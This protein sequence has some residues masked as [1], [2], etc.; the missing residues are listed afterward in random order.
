MIFCCKSNSIRVLKYNIFVVFSA[1][2]VHLSR[3]FA[4]FA[5]MKR[6]FSLF[7]LLLMVVMT[8]ARHYDMTGLRLST[9]DGL[10]TNAVVRIGQNRQ[11]YIVLQ[12]RNGTCL[13]DGY[14]LRR[15]ENS[16][17]AVTDTDKELRT[18]DAV[19]T[20]CGNGLLERRGREGRTDR[21]QLIPPEIISYTRNDHFHVAD[22]DEHTEAIA[23]YGSGLFL[24]DKPTGELTQLTQENSQGLLADDYLTGLFV[25]RT[26][27]IWIIEDYLGVKMLRPN[28]LNYELLLP[29]AQAHIEDENNIRCIAPLEDDHLLVS[30]QTSDVYDYDVQTGS[31]S[32]LYRSNHRVY[33]ALRDHQGRLW[34]GTRGGGLLCDGKQVDSLPSPHIFNLR[35][36]DKGGI[37]VAMLEGGVT[38]INGDKQKHLLKG[39]NVH[40]AIMWQGYLWAA[41]EEGLFHVDN[42]WAVSDS[43][44]GC[45]IC[46]YAD[47]KGSLW[48]GSNDRGV[49]RI[50][51]TEDRHISASFFHTGNGLPSNGV[52]AIS[53]DHSH[54]LWIST[55][56]GLACINP[57]TGDIS[58]YNIFGSPLLN[59]FNERAAVCLPDGRLL[60]GSRGGIVVVSGQK[61]RPE[62]QGKTAVTA[63]TVNGQLASADR[64]LSH[65]ENNLT[66]SFSNFQ[67]ADLQ[68]VHYQYWLEGYDTE[69]CEPTKDHT[70][71]YRHLPPGH[72]VF[73]VRSWSGTGQWSEAANI[74]ITISKPWWDTWWAWLLYIIMIIS[75]TR[76]A[77]GIARRQLRLRRQIDVQRQVNALQ[78]DF[79]GRIEREMRSP[80]NVVQGATEQVRLGETT[81]TTK[82]SLRRGALRL[83]K[84][85]E[86][87]GRYH[88]L[89][90]QELQQKAEHDAMNQETEKLFADIQ[91]TNRRDEPEFREMVPPPINAQT[92]IIAS[93]DADS[94]AHLKDIV[95]P[96]FRVQEVLV[97]EEVTTAVNEYAPD[98][99]MI[100]MNN[101][102]QECLDLT[103]Q[104]VPV[105]LSLPIVHLS[106]YD[107]DE[108]QLRS[109]RS[110]ASDYIVKPVGNR[111]LLE[112][113]KKL[114]AA[115]P[116]PPE[117]A[118]NSA[119][120][121]APPEQ[122]LTSTKDK[123]F[124]N[125]MQ[126]T[127]SAH[128]A[129]E[130]FSVEQ[131]AEAMDLGRTQ[132]Y[133]K[134]KTLTGETPM[135]HLQRER[136]EQAARLLRETRLTVENIMLR[137]GY[138]NASH[139][140][141]TF[142]R[143]FGV[144][145]KVMRNNEQ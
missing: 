45:F 2:F 25:D 10:P 42:S 49:A 62:A 114:L 28:R 134:V 105:H 57:V 92:V 5:P 115:S 44:S 123:R 140:Y 61:Q 117:P 64:R 12:T 128:I 101:H 63:L 103:R 95:S 46:L 38:I 82:Q 78:R 112:R 118:A 132:F 119:A 73:H 11:G 87:I 136:M 39:K 137:V 51:M 109:L 79:L 144:S 43:L 20:R 94:L 110:G 72:Y 107:D 9:A 13:Y 70:A 22:V 100:D 65:Q 19:Y 23:T 104:I 97:L 86:M 58:S 71:N 55:E 138:R 4:I 93:E 14:Q 125:Q 116:A 121:A 47:S 84:L 131:W 89:S 53:E 36:D 106:S 29:N 120:S 16:E 135:A 76:I 67:F 143:Q 59:V 40:D 77:V 90:E 98:L 7:C 35:P 122:I 74:D 108:H 113:L 50:S 130:N 142:K 145:P 129:E 83:R 21:W 8:T 88:S 127:L 75:T 54:Q 96:F 56:E 124:L 17:S 69:W 102:E 133:K 52:N 66:F 85:M 15:V 48:A 33:T 80:V 91:Q 27:C 1:V 41:T 6:A 24:Y 141:T 31:M 99:L 30:N 126:A 37:I 34:L 32:R 60:F 26:G 3:I 81:K 139:F 68:S 18:H 111:V